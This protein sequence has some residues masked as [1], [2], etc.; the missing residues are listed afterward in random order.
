MA[1]QIAALIGI[2][3][4]ITAFRA[5]G[6]TGLWIASSVLWVS[7]GAMAILR[8]R[9]YLPLDSVALLFVVLLVGWIAVPAYLIDRASIRSPALGLW[10]QSLYG[11]VG[12]NL[13][14]LGVLALLFAYAVAVLLI[15]GHG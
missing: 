11:W 9:T 12:Y 8:G 10:K 4:A 13:A 15:R 1:Q 14:G 6:R 5:F 7:L 2:P 3:I